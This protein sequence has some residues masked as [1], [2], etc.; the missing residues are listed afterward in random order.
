MPPIYDHITEKYKAVVSIYL[1]D[2]DHDA[3]IE[4]DSGY[5]FSTHHD[6]NDAED[7]AHELYRDL[8]INREEFMDYVKTELDT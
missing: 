5:V 1:D 3:F 7:L 8:L 4:V 2:E 6:A